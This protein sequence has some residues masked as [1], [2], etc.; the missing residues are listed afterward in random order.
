MENVRL[1]D[2]VK[3]LG[4]KKVIDGSDGVYVAGATISEKSSGQDIRPTDAVY[5]NSLADLPAPSSGV[6]QLAAAD[7]IFINPISDSNQWALPNGASIQ[8]CA[9]KPGV[10]INYTGTS[11]FIINNPGEKYLNFSINGLTMIGP[12]P[13]VVGSKL[14]EVVGFSPSRVPVPTSH[15][16]LSISNTEMFSF[17]EGI[18]VTDSVVNLNQTAH[19]DFVK[20]MKLTNV[21]A[22]L[23]NIDVENDAAGVYPGGD[24]IEVV[25]GAFVD[26]FVRINQARF[27]SRSIDFI[28]N[29]DPAYVGKFVCSESSN[30]NLQPAFN[31]AG[32]NQ[33][34]DDIRVLD[35]LGFTVSRTLG[36]IS[37]SSP[38]VVPIT[39]QGQHEPVAGTSWVTLPLTERFIGAPDGRL[40]YDSDTPAAVQ[41]VCNST[42]QKVGGGTDEIEF[43]PLINGTPNTTGC[44]STRSGD[45]TSVTAIWTVNCVKG[46]ELRV[47]VANLTGTADVTVKVSKLLLMKIVA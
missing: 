27:S 4:N 26:Q 12:G 19:V 10:S 17:A 13:G 39:V 14:M 9:N 8:L 16:T 21:S 43:C 18:D 11:T 36:E 25:N 37:L 15:S 40:I 3:S 5:V 41:I 24:M 35:G 31:P 30:F 23:L 22:S 44:T 29:I 45:P 1:L 47:G 28:F 42:V 33:K 2:Y 46:T 7:Y 32:L 6:R 34:S 38:T 20:H